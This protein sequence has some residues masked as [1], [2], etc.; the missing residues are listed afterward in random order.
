M[1]KVKIGILNL[2][3]DKI[4]TQK[5]FYKVWPNAELIFLYPR[6]HYQN[7]PFPAEVAATSEPLDISRIN[8]FDGFIITGAPIDHLA[9]KDVYFKN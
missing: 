6:S 2:M 8:E 4:D 3:H 1:V 9:F 7:R 5:R